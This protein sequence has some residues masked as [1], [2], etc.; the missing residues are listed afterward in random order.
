[1]K[2]DKGM[3]EK[4]LKLSY[5]E[6]ATKPR[7]GRKFWTGIAILL[8]LLQALLIGA[9]GWVGI[10]LLNYWAFSAWDNQIQ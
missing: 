9:A 5:A 8:I 4:P 1:M 3:E 7:H 10:Q 2:K 6:P